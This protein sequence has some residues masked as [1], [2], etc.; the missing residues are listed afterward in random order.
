MF[1]SAFHVWALLITIFHLKQD[2]SR[3][4]GQQEQYTNHNVSSCAPW[5]CCSAYGTSC[6]LATFDGLY[7]QKEI[8]SWVQAEVLCIVYPNQKKLVVDY[9]VGT[10]GVS[11]H[12]KSQYQNP[13][14]TFRH[15]HKMV[16]RL[17]HFC[18]W[19]IKKNFIV[20]SPDPGAECR[21]RLY[22]LSFAYT[23]PILVIFG[24]VKDLLGDYLANFVRLLE[25]KSDSTRCL[26]GEFHGPRGFRGCLLHL[27][28]HRLT[29]SRPTHA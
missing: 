2:Q 24:V 29:C 28:G 5:G 18:F 3:R 13:R 23:R 6:L 25:D 11:T 26:P 17:Y 8:T 14:S 4:G 27:Q 9:P 21:C 16:Q 20:F 22:H 12:Q 15:G 10:N 1:S 7:F 19:A